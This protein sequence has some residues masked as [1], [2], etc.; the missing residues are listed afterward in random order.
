MSGL[1]TN[2]EPFQHPTSVIRFRV[3]GADWSEHLPPVPDG[4]GVSVSFT[5]DTTHRRHAAA[6]F[7]LGYRIVE[8]DYAPNA[9]ADGEFV[10]MVVY[11]DI[12]V[13]E[14]TWWTAVNA[15]AERVY[16]L[17]MGPCAAMWRALVRAHVDDKGRTAMHAG[18]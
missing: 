12:A 17:A 6:L 8:L 5:C 15:L 14:P 3:D 7:E 2:L 18:A 10:D 16:A 1:M 4:H 11:G 13:D 9:H